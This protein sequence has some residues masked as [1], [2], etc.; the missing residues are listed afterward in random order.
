MQA[1]KLNFRSPDYTTQLLWNSMTMMS[2]V[3]QN[4][5][6][7]WRKVCQGKENP[8]WANEFKINNNIN[9]IRLVAVQVCLL[10]AGIW[11]DTVGCLGAM[12]GQPRGTELLRKHLSARCEYLRRSLSMHIR[13]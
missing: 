10:F 8:W 4:Q 11:R 2:W 9:N 5:K 13:E 6:G 12:D 3:Y 7:M 1:I